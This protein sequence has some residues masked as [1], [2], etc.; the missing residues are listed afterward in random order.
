LGFQWVLIGIQFITQA[1]IPDEPEEI[2]I[3]EKR[4]A[5]IVSKVIDRTPDEDSVTVEDY[6]LEQRQ[7]L[8]KVVVDSVD[9]GCC[10]AFFGGAPH[11]QK[12]SKVKEFGKAPTVD[13]SKYAGDDIDGESMNPLS[14]A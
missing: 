9:K 1:I 12:L 11:H 13:I 7:S 3:Q 5:F 4:Q 6:E 2:L 10:A 8:A 14:K